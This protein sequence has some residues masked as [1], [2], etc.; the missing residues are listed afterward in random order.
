MLRAKKLLLTFAVLTTLH[1][2]PAQARG[3]DACRAFDMS[4]ANV[5]VVRLRN[6]RDRPV[7]LSLSIQ[8]DDAASSRPKACGRLSLPAG[9]DA[10]LV[11]LAQQC[12]T[13]TSTQAGILK[14]CV[15]PTAAPPRHGIATGDLGADLLGNNL[16]VAGR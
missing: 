1:A 13:A 3:G 5:R 7:T 15:L 8:P 10:N 14:A 4:D 16:P 9:E 6:P 11:T 12:A 2:A